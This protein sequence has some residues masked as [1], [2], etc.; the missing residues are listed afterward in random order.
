[1]WWPGLSLTVQQRLAACVVDPALA[2]T[3]FGPILVA[4]LGRWLELW[5]PREVWTLL[6]S[7][8]CLRSQPGLWGEML[9][10]AP[11]AAAELDVALAGWQRLRLGHERGELPCYWLGERPSEASLPNG[12]PTGLA[13]RHD[14]LARSLAER[15]PESTPLTALDTLAL[16][17]TLGPLPLLTLLDAEHWQDGPALGKVL[18][19]ANVPC[20]PWPAGSVQTL[21]VLERQGLRRLMS[22]LGLAVWPACGLTLA[23]L[24]LWAPAAALADRPSPG[25]VPGALPEVDYPA[26]GL[27]Y[28]ELGLDVERALPALWDD[29]RAYWYAL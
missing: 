16:C 10:T 9:I 18:C 13:E 25:E 19:E 3:P 4:R 27:D 21:A 11:P 2:L 1:M 14:T 23:V 15:V 12:T 8:D 20:E 26:H 7:S 5:L 6:D 17:A 22:Q 29:A 24:H 28:A